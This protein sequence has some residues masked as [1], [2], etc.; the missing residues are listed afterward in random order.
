MFP[1]ARSQSFMTLSLPPDASQRLYGSKATAMAD[2]VCPVCRIKTGLS[3]GATGGKDEGVCLG[4]EVTPI[5][6]FSSF[7]CAM[8]EIGA[9][10][11][12]S[13]SINDES[14]RQRSKRIGDLW[15][16]P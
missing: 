1:V 2:F 4:A 3:P 6:R 8:L 16:A 15:E 14:S 10:N 9:H 11:R 13:K 12:E 5:P 7:D